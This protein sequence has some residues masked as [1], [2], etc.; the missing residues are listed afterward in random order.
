MIKRNKFNAWKLASK[1]LS[2]TSIFPAGRPM[3]SDWRMLNFDQ[4]LLGFKIQLHHTMV[5]V[6]RFLIHTATIC[7]V[8]S[9]SSSSFLLCETFQVQK[10]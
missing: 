8:L 10:S 5:L 7:K 3:V 4:T 9:N 1:E 6:L 2:M